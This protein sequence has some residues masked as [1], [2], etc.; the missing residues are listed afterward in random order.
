MQYAVHYDKN[1]RP[2]GS[3]EVIFER[4]SDAFQAFKRYNNVQLDG[5]PMKIEIIGAKAET[6]VSGRVNVVGGSNGRRTVVMASGPSRSRGGFTASN[7]RGGFTAANRRGGFTAANRGSAQRGRG[8]LSS[9]HR[10]RG[11]RG[12]GGGRGG[13]RWVK[14]NVEKS[15]D[16]LDKELESYHA[17]AMQT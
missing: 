2:S 1:G 12:R 14:K 3:A 7:R 9:G 17:E 13:G 6:S 5:K 15:A 11:G 10:G 4:R 8:G 16:E